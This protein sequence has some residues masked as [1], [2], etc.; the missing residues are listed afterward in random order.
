[1]LRLKEWAFLLRSILD[2]G[3]MSGLVV[4]APSRFPCLACTLHMASVEEKT[5]SKNNVN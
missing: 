4:P 5:L 1:M 3:L 2:L